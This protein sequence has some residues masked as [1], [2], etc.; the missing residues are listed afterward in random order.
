MRLDNQHA[1]PKLS[2]YTTSTTT[3]TT[4]AQNATPGFLFCTSVI[5]ACIA[6][7]EQPPVPLHWF[8]P[9]LL[10]GAEQRRVSYRKPFSVVVFTLRDNDYCAV[11]KNFGRVGD[12][13][14]IHDSLHWPAADDV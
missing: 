13:P 14:P 2:G 8:T 4:V 6:N 12:V 7:R 1:G 3:T 5:V 11:G 9:A 10:S